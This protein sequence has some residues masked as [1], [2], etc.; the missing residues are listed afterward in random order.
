MVWND[1]LE[2]IMELCLVWND[3]NL[4]G[5][6]WND[7]KANAVIKE[8]MRI[9]MSEALESVK[10]LRMSGHVRPHVIPHLPT[11]GPRGRLPD[12]AGSEA[13]CKHR[14]CPCEC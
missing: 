5:M 12:S 10:E 1:G 2:F 4:F 13:R 11:M 6:A 3:V 14:P 9:H 8:F 7:V